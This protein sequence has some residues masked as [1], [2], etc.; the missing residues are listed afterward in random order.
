MTQVYQDRRTGKRVVRIGAQP[1]EEGFVM[2]KGNEGPPY[3]ISIKNLVP[4]DEQGV[5]DFDA[6]GVSVPDELEE[7]PPA[8]LVAIADNRL[9]VN[10]ATAEQL[11]DR[12]KGLPY[13]TAKR[14]KQLQL[15]QPGE[16][17]QTLDQ[18]REAS[19]RVNWDEVFRQNDI[20]VG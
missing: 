4:V 16:V 12:V 20:F 8:P 2:V 15:Q 14:I 9:N 3:H 17:F 18:L 19:T 1:G 11:I 10:T 13:R 6:P 5:P 7:R